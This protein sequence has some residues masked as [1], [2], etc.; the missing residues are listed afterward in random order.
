MSHV[1]ASATGSAP[2]R[3]EYNPNRRRISLNRIFQIPQMFRPAVSLFAG[4][5]IGRV[6]LERPAIGLTAVASWFRFARWRRM[7]PVERPADGKRR[8]R[9]WLYQTII[10]KERLNDEPI[11]FWEFG[12]F[13]GESLFAWL[14]N[15][16]HPN[17]SFVGFDTF[18]GLPERWRATEAE[19]AFNVY[20]EIPETSDTRCSFVVG[21]FQKTLLSYVRLHDFSRRLV[22]HLDADLYSS[23]L[24]VLTTLAPYFKPG[25]IIFFDNFICS[26]DEFRAFEDFVKAYRVQYEVLGAVQEYIRVCVKIMG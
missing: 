2:V 19:G 6:N 5:T 14:T 12:V 15:I 22:I 25:D 24:F 21:L 7:H 8:D 16:S 23:T 18:T 4:T 20:G 13:R 11:D 3:V 17:S 10:Q 9:V 26:V 1:S